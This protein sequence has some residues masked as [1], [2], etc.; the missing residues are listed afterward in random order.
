MTKKKVRINN[1]AAESGR[2]AGLA[3]VSLFFSGCLT[4]LPVHA[5][6]EIGTTG[7]WAVTR[8]TIDGERLVGVY[9]AADLVNVQTGEIIKGTGL[10]N[11]WLVFDQL[12]AGNYALNNLL[13]PTKYGLE[14]VS[15]RSK[16]REFTVDGRAIYF[17]GTLTGVEEFSPKEVPEPAAL[18]L[19][20][21]WQPIPDNDPAVLEIQ[22]Y[23][24]GLG[25]GLARDYFQVVKA[26]GDLTAT[27]RLWQSEK[28]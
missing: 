22:K 15:L 6:A 23:A 1:L 2:W 3:L 10:W 8:I 14:T 13:F 28:N 19:T 11:G 5:L 24:G 4:Y 18:K 26:V 7:S 9:G 25:K 27:F 21:Q 12:P 20:L 17:L 16:A